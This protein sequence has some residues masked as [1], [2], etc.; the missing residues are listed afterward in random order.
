MKRSITGETIRQEFM[1]FDAP[2]VISLLWQVFEESVLSYTSDGKPLPS[3]LLEVYET[4]KQLS[5]NC[6]LHTLNSVCVRVCVCM[7]FSKHRS[8]DKTVEMTF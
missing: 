3:V 1:E 6:I 5:K 7:L 8:V 2:A 4:I